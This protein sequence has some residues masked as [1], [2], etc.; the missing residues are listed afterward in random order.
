MKLFLTD[1]L[2]QRLSGGSR[3]SDRLFLRAG[4]RELKT[5]PDDLRALNQM[6]LSVSIRVR[7]RFV[8]TSL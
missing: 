8:L 3:S 1:D 7:V 6:L 4:L 5:P 2:T